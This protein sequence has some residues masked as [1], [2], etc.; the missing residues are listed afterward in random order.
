MNIARGSIERPVTTWLLI[1][2]LFFGGVW[3]YLC[4]GRLEDPAFTIKNAVISTNYPGAS[5]EQ[6]SVEVTE[7]IPWALVVSIIRVRAL[8]LD[9]WPL[10]C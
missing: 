1:L 8:E 3:G 4:L 2:T 7:R 9:V 5:A 10:T 6:V